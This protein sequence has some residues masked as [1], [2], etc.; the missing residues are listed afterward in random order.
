LPGITIS[1]KEGVE[2]LRRIA[3]NDVAARVVVKPIDRIQ[4][5]IS[6]FPARFSPA[7]ALAMGFAADTG[8]DAIVKDYI[9]S[10]GIKV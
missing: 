8:I 3:G 10:E 4:T 5:M 9:A 6:T 7:R 1:V 2:A